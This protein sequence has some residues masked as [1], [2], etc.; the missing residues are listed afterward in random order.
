MSDRNTVRDYLQASPE[1]MEVLESFGIRLDPFTII[2]L[3]ATPEQLAEYSALRRP[4]DL[5]EAL[6]R[7]AAAS[8]TQPARR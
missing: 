5:R 2:A 4:A 1:T 7:L 6:D 3:D 8:E